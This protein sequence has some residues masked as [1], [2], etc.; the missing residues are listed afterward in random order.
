MPHRT[1]DA[2][3]AGV[4]FAGS[5]EAA[6]CTLAG[7]RQSGQSGQPGQSGGFRA[8]AGLIA[9]YR[10][11]GPE[12][13]SH[14]LFC[15]VDTAQISSAADQP[16]LVIRNEEVFAEK[17]RERTALTRR[18]STVVS[19]VLLL[20]SENGTE[21]DRQLRQV[22]AK[23]GEPA[24][25]DSEPEGRTHEVWE[26]R[27]GADADL[28][29]RL[30]GA[31]PL[32]VADGN[33]RSLSAQQ[34][35][36]DRFLA[37]VTT[38]ESVRLAPYNRLVTELGMSLPELLTRLEVVGARVSGPT[39]TSTPAGV[40]EPGSFSRPIVI[41]AG[42]QEYMVCLPLPVTDRLAERLDHA[43]VERVLFGQVLGFGPADHRIRYIGGDYGPGWLRTEVDEGRAA[44]AVLI[45][46]VDVADF[47]AVNLARETL[48]RKSTW[49]VP[50]AR[51]GLVLA[52]VDPDSRQFPDHQ[53]QTEET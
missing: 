1:P 18:L 8:V 48:P 39:D 20:K 22:I 15:M 29:L 6:A 2:V 28:L 9:P 49:F 14:G 36:L 47:M 51:A 43:V 5:L 40:L 45:P 16:G 34:A 46:A 13:L 37:V 52:E 27:A 26:L 42:G 25:T 23:L 4:S 7:L 17:V 33:H 10:I 44:A 3:A 35:G 31:G 53:T 12:G 21:F 50:K 11:T 38:A 30:A 19:P 32:V 41:L 24:V